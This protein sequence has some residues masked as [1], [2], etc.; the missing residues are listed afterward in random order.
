MSKNGSLQRLLS[1]KWNQALTFEGFLNYSRKNVD[2]MRKN[3][4]KTEV[5]PKLAEEVK[6]FEGKARILVIGAD[7]CGDVVAN[8]PAIARLAELSGNLQLRIIDRDIHEDLM[9]EFLTNGTK[10][11]PKVVVCSSNMSHCSSWGPRPAACQ[12]IMTENKDKLPK[13]EIYT[14]LRDWYM[15][16]KNQSVMKE[17]W[18]EVKAQAEPV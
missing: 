15:N 1:E 9:K 7:W 18:D 8:L 11:I 17:I 3:F 2:A 5:D 13:E 10:S 14:L 12:T 6:A 16:D 4:E